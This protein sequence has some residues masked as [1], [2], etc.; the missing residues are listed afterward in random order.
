MRTHARDLLWTV[1]ATSFGFV[2]AQLDV[3]IVNVALPSIAS[4]LGA[5]VAA[6]Q[7]VVDGYTL[8]FAV[9]L[10]SAG[11]LGD[12]YGS[13]R[14][15]Q[16]GFLLFGA[17]SAACGL[18]PHAAALVA[19]RAVQGAGAALLVPNSLALLNH[20]TGHASDVRARAVGQ[21]TAAGAISIA[22]GPVLGSLLLTA[23][24]W[25]SIFLVNL[26]LCAIGVWLVGAHVPPA[27]K[28]NT[29]RGLDV[30]GQ[31]FAVLALTGMTG[32]VI[33]WRPLGA[34]HPVVAGGMLLA[35]VAGA[36]FVWTEAH[37]RTPMLP[38][39]FFRRPNFTPAVAFGVLV[40]FT[41]YGMI[42]VLSL[43]LQQALGYS[44]L[45][46]GLAYLPLTGSF[47]VSNLLS[48]RVAARVGSRLPM[49]VG[50]LVGAL[51]YVLLVRLDATSSYGEMLP[52][53]LLIPSGMGFAVPAMT[54]ATLA[55]VDREWSG[56]ASAVLNAARQAGAAI[57]VALFGALVAGG[58]AH[59]VTGV[60]RAALI[61][62]A[63]LLLGSALAWTSIRAGRH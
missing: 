55:S 34:S 30:P 63:M 9:L 1:T 14:A 23:F 62:T 31:I 49:T 2:V 57:G 17:A 6:L 41:Y 32:A 28:S 25:R 22:A 46:A 13:K 35:L 21:W 45:R 38:L 29:P 19:A 18:A 42:F 4:D 7:W 10:L 33:E 5:G 61:S 16:C 40:N 8:A 54:T 59:I 20:A 58:P 56:T 47:F 27:P 37:A 26:P 53:F 50:A 36:A 60:G 39:R 15:Y 3:T 44:V 48:G 51:G 24:G 43:Y 11:V 12:R 52:A